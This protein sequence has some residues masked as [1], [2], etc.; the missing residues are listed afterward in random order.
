MS[1][2]GDARGSQEDDWWRQLYDEGAAAGASG[3]GNDSLDAHF[4][5]ALNAMTPPPPPP[6]ETLRLRRPTPP[7]P[8]SSWPRPNRPVVPPPMP[9]A[10]RQEAPAVPPA[11]PWDPWAAAPTFAEPPQAPP[12]APQPAPEPTPDP[13]S[14]PEEVEERA[15]AAP[16]L[17]PRPGFA[18]DPRAAAAYAPEPAYEAEPAPGPAPGPV[19]EPAAEPAPEPPHAP[20]PRAS[21]A[22]APPPATPWDAWVTP[23]RAAAPPPAPSAPTAPPPA[24]DWSSQQ[25]P[26]PEPTPEPTPEPEPPA[27]PP[28]YVDLVDDPAAGTSTP[29]R[30]ESVDARP[31]EAPASP[32]PYADLVPDPAAH[33]PEPQEPGQ[34][35][36]QAQPEEASTHVPGAPVDAPPAPVDARPAEAPALP[37]PYADLVPDPAAHRPQL[38]EPQLPEGQAQPAEEPPPV[39]ETPGPAAE[40]A[41]VAPPTPA[42]EAPVAGAA[43]DTAFGEGEVRWAPELPPGWVPAA[44]PVQVVDAAT[45]VGVVGGGPPTYGA[46]PTAWP[47]ADPDGLD[48]LVPDTVLDGAAYGVLTL[49]SAAVRGD[50]ARYR[51]EPRR[52]ALL[53][54]RFGT[55]DG[56]LLLVAMAS[57]A[58]GADDAHR[59]AQDAVRWIAG[60]VGRS[61]ARLADDIRA[62]RRGS[63]KS[64]LHRLTDRCYGRLRARGEDLGLDEGAYTASVRCLLLP[65]DP[66]CRIRLFFGVGEGGL[67]RIREGAWQ[68]LDRAP[69]EASAPFRFR[70]AVAQPG[71]ALVM[72]SAGLAEPLRGEPGLADHLAGRWGQGRPPGL[73]AYLADA[74]TRVKGYADDRTVVTVWDA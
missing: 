23:R 67:F 22:Y 74:Q 6:T 16:E 70:A 71:D 39:P 57:G 46:E 65:V 45:E 19:P 37:S 66:E 68:D 18:P 30:D 25:P 21:D 28:P 52:D 31:A 42:P 10:P 35:E 5:S 59:A 27:A 11:P 26:A 63:L 8:P 54:A 1:Q 58:R 72:C 69:D 2:Q 56:A 44:A 13:E 4:D 33:R 60:A 14:A 64:G 40:P 20:D 62:A 12:Q 41:P 7:P 9:P 29:L 51:G 49:R 53:T 48:A 34:P 15:S 38:Q 55:G 3:A 24:E 36:G 17:P 50:S 61:R 73:A 32:S 43:G 47:E